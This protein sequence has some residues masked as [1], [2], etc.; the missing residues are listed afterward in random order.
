MTHGKG[1]R[2]YTLVEDR[3]GSGRSSRKGSAMSKPTNS[4]F[5]IIEVSQVE[6]VK[7]GRKSAVSP[8]LVEALRGLQ[9]GKALAIKSHA[10]DPTSADFARE[11]SRLASQIRTACREAG[12][13]SYR[14]LWSPQGIPQV[15]R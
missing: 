13:P 2:G 1:R 10:T 15:V 5:E 3:K 14:I 4:D 8:A 6:F 7:R 12:L 9:V 11:K